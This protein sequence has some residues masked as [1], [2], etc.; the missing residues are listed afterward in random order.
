MD[1]VTKALQ[2]IDAKV[3]DQPITVKAAHLLTSGDVKLY[4]STRCEANWLLNNRHAWYLLADPALVTQPPRYPVILH[5]VPSTIGV[6][7]GVFAAKLVEQTVG[8][9]ELSM[10]LDGSAI[11]NPP[12]K[13]WFGCAEPT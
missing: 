4:T 1:E 8:N 10:E 12:V 5:L 2:K 6:D 3:E 13:L 7:C 9:P 11:P